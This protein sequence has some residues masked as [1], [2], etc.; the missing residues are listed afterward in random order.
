MSRVYN[1]QYLVL[2]EGKVVQYLSKDSNEAIL[3]MQTYIKRNKHS[4][5]Y[6][7]QVHAVAEL[8]PP[9]ITTLAHEVM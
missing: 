4:E 1:G 9:I 3:Y 6:L 5:P 2:N 7:V 8:P